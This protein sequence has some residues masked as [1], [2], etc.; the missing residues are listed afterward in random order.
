MHHLR[1]EDSG[2]G[3]GVLNTMQQVG[4]ALGLA[5]LATVATQTFDDRGDELATAAERRRAGSEPDQ[6]EAMAAITQSQVFTEG[7]TDAFL[8]GASL[9]LGASLVVWLFLNV[10]HD[11]ARDRR[12]GDPGPRRL[13]FGLPGRGPGHRSGDRALVVLVL[14]FVELL[15]QSITSAEVVRLIRW[16]CTTAV[17]SSTGMLRS[18]SP[19]IALD[20]VAGV[21]DDD[22]LLRAAH[23]HH[24]DPGVLLGLDVLPGDDQPATVHLLLLAPVH[25]AARVDVTPARRDGHGEQVRRRTR[26]R[27]V[28]ELGTLDAVSS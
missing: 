18:S 9:M 20:V 28:A 23:G 21:V 6:M 2:I 17:M 14:E 27:A 25:L 1:N 22:V 12:P 5:L 8:L 3:S 11:G 19:R 13:R 16:S 4:G 15:A 24:H 10:K 26:R 7:A